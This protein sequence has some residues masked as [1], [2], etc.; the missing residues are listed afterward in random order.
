MTLRVPNTKLDSTLRAMSYLVDFLDSRSV[1]AK[2]IRIELLANKLAIVRLKHHIQ[3]VETDVDDKGQKLRETT[4]AEEML[5]NAQEQSDMTRLDNMKQIDSIKYS[6]I[7]LNIYQRQ[8]IK[9]TLLA[10]EKDIRQY[11]PGFFA[12]MKEAFITGWH[13]VEELVLM[14]VDIWWFLLLVVGMIIGYLR[15]KT[16]IN[17]HHKK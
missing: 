16:Y 17:K 8:T 6:T 1:Q 14:L 9:R 5:L 3:R 7:V 11:E 15:Y 12:R 13:G 2:D 4:N 10:N